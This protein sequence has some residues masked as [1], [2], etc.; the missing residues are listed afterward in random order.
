MVFTINLGTQTERAETQ[1]ERA[2]TQTKRADTQTSN[3]GGPI[4]GG[5]PIA[6]ATWGQALQG[7][8]EQ[9]VEVLLLWL[10][11]QLELVALELHGVCHINPPD[12]VGSPCKGHGRGVPD[13]RPARMD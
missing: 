10:V 2:E 9:P 7:H 3:R 13:P 8:H 12:L 11:S 5:C 6:P 1:T 4:L